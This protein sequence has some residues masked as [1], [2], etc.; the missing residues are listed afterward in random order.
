MSGQKVSKRSGRRV[1]GKFLCERFDARRL[2]SGRVFR[3][4]ESGDLPNVFRATR[5]WARP[6]S[7]GLRPSR[8]RSHNG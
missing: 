6:V 5:P 7:I 2:R 1:G 8:W 4:A 3:V